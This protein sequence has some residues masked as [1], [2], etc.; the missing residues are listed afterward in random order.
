MTLH[1]LSEADL[2]KLIR[3]VEPP[4][5]QTAAARSAEL[6]QRA[7]S[8][9]AAGDVTRALAGVA[10]LA[11]L[12]PRRAESAPSEPAFQKI[13]TEVDLLLARLRDVARLDA[14]TRIG[15]AAA[16][17]ESAALA[18]LDDWDA[19]PR[20]LLQVAAH[21]LEHGG[22]ASSLHAAQLAQSILDQAARVPPARSPAGLSAV[23]ALRRS[24]TS[25]IERVRT[26]WDRA[27]LL[28]LLLS[29]L[30]LGLTGAAVSALSG[31]SSPGLVELWATGFL[32]LVVFGFYMRVR[33]IRF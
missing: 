12:D 17:T 6:F 27:P 22:Y 7:A 21:L 2:A 23:R 26:L 28:V 19:P 32:G 15:R 20:R 8:F 1:G 5:L 18:A 30:V 3:I 11:R 25:T 33:N 4:V 9:A 31:I 14:E 10:E 16:A 13:R 24:W 29:W